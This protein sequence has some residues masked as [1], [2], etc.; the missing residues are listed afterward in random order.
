[1]T[2][3]TRPA[4]DP[5]RLNGHT[6]AATTPPPPDVRRRTVMEH[7][8]G[9][10]RVDVRELWEYRSLIV[11]LI[12]RH[13]QVRY[14]QSV[15]GVGWSLIRPLISMIVFTVVF[16]RFVKIPSD[17]RPY[18]VF[19]LA[20]VVPWTYFATALGG[21]SES[22]TAS[23]SM[24]TKVYFPRMALPISF[25]AAPL[26][27]L[28]IGMV[29]LLLMLIWYGITPSISSL[30][31]IPLLI[32][33]MMLTATGVGCIVTALDIQYRDLKQ[34]VPFLLQVWMYVSPVV[35]P[36]SMV[37]PGYRRLY[38]LNPMA[39]TIAAFRSV[40]LGTDSGDWY[41]VGR[42]LATS[43]LICAVGVVYFRYRE[44]VFADVV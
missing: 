3:E 39:G 42:A 13:V 24:I 8:R 20:A 27:D 21:V 23:G 11:T 14:A 28:A 4:S 2:Q 30:V 25:V 18:P 31:I 16:Q 34:L 7:S 40:L 6:R 5:L 12:A 32:L 38:D 36:M 10:R 26:V 44:P 29:L 15:L 43:S 22:L 17:G 9:L 37:P 35:Y 33:A 41:S 19:S 1:M